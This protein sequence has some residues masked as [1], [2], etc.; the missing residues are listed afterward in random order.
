M[1][2]GHDVGALVDWAV[3]FQTLWTERPTPRIGIHYGSTLYRDGDYF[4]RDVNLA[5]RVVARARGGE[6][7]VTDTVIDAIRDTD[8]LE[9]ENI[10]EVKLK[11]FDEPRGAVPG[12]SHARMTPL[13][14]ARESGL[15]RAGEPL[16]V[17]LSGGADSVCLLDVAVELE[18]GVVG[19]ARELRAARR[20]PT[21]T[22][23]SAASCASGSG[24]RSRSSAPPAPPAGNLQ[25]EARDVRYAVAERLAEGDYATAHTLSDQAETVALPAR[26]LAGPARAARDGAAPRPAGAAAARGDPRRD[27]RAGAGGAASTG[28]RTP[29]TPTSLRARACEARGACRS[30]AS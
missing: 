18:A 28:A 12:V 30:C 4:G 5:A 2:V 23:R 6:V 21:A 29:R 13:D 19:A 8:H 1:V 7:L 11:G 26:R 27:A 20:A 17:L 25:A 16:L 9:F 22:R 3:G 15:V 24:C 14:A 10:G